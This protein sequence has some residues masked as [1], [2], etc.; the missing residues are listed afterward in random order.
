MI[1]LLISCLPEDFRDKHRARWTGLNRRVAW[2]LRRLVSGRR[3][4]PVADEGIRVH[5]GCGKIDLPGFVNIDAAPHRHVHYLGPLY[6][7]PMLRDGSAS[8]IYASHCL[9]HFSYRQVPS[10]LKEWARVLRPGGKL[11]LGVPDFAAI[12]EAYQASDSDL[13]GVMGPL[14][15]GQDY[16]LNF[17]HVAFDQKHLTRLLEEA[18]F[19]DIRPWTPGQDPW[20]PRNDCS[21]SVVQVS[22][23]TF[24]VSLN[25]EARK[26]SPA[27]SL[28]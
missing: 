9:E 7:L 17:H 15:G 28:P 23:G 18:G 20:S 25:L 13:A 21:S 12:V 14:M 3:L 5:L 6:P 24:P 26:K 8:L 27:S 2:H 1:K 16:P 4:P 22:G 11:R 10:I 19:E